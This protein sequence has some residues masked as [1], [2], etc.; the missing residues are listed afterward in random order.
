MS[1]AGLQFGW[2]RMGAGLGAVCFVGFGVGTIGGVRF[3]EMV[4]GGGVG[5]CGGCLCCLVG[6]CRWSGGV[7][8][9]FVVRGFRFRWTTL[10]SLLSLAAAVACLMVLLSVSSLSFWAMRSAISWA[11]WP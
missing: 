8:V 1:S 11:S 4:E 5:C 7:G 9:M 3:C 6:G 10:S 2:G